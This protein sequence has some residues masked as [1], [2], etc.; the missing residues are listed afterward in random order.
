LY[1]ILILDANKERTLLHKIMED[2][3]SS[4]AIV[5]GMT[6]NHTTTTT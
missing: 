5:V 2:S 3:S 4:Y 1:R 6:H